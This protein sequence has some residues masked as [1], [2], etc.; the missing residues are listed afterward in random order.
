MRSMSR[1]PYRPTP[2]MNVTPLVDVVLVLLIIFM[3]V[4]PAMDKDAPVELPSIFNVDPE[5]KSKVDP[6][7]L[8]VVADGSMYFEQ[9]KL[10]DAT[11]AKVLREANDRDP[12]RRVILRADR[13]A[14]YGRVR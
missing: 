6:Y 10:D 2:V 5:A 3:V 14:K 7:T 13:T 4:I 12:S 1:N 11:F 9:D 8:S